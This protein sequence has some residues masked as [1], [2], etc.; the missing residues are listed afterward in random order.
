M[1]AKILFSRGVALGIYLLLL[2]GVF[3]TIGRQLVRPGYNIGADFSAFYIAGEFARDGRAVEVYGPTALYDRGVQIAGGHYPIP[4]HYPPTYIWFL[5]FLPLLPY[6][7]ATLLWGFAGLGVWWAIDHSLRKE[8]KDTV[9]LITIIGLTLMLCISQGQNGWITGALLAGVR[10]QAK[11]RPYLAGALL[12]LLIFKPQFGF[13]A[14]VILLVTQNWRALTAA[15]ICAGVIILG[16]LLQFGLDP[17]IAFVENIP[18]AHSLAHGP[19]GTVRIANS[20]M[21]TITPM[22]AGWGAPDFLISITQLVV[23]SG[24]VMCAAWIWLTHCNRYLQTAVL[25]IST[26]LAMP[27]A[28]DYDMVVV[29]FSAFCLLQTRTRFSW[30]E[31]I[32]IA[33]LVL[34]P[35]FHMVLRNIIP[36]ALGAPILIAG[37]VVCLRARHRISF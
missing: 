11:P 18:F 5:Q 9:P 3:S 4:F 10:L 6:R 29:S 24:A 14:C 17:W 22:L 37:L 21:V 16:S 33:L 2:I 35:M 13:A 19:V 36:G 28:F 31:K 7:T 20:R 25:G 27:F 32:I 26:I 15:A 34:W 30:G 8:T 12:G 1:V 23:L